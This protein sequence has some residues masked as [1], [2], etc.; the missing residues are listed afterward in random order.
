MY[1]LLRN[2]LD[3]LKRGVRD[4]TQ[5][6]ISTPSTTYHEGAVAAKIERKLTEL[7]Y[8]R[9]FR[10]DSGNVVGILLGREAAPTMLLTSHMDTVD[11][12][13]N[14][15]WE[16]DPLAGN[17][18]DGKIYGLGAADCKGGLAAQMYAGAL[19][20]RSLLPLQGNLV[21]AATVAEGNGC[22]TGI[23][24]FLKKTISDIG[25]SP[26][27]AVLG[28][29]TNLG[30][31]YGH[32]GWVQIELKLNG[33]NP[34]HV[35]D[36]VSALMDSFQEEDAASG[37]TSET[38]SPRFQDITERGERSATIT[39]NRRMNN[40]DEVEDVL[41]Q[42]RR[43]ARL[44][45][46]DPDTSIQVQVRQGTEKMYNGRTELVRHSSSGWSIDPYDPL[47]VRA[48]QSLAAAGTRVHPGRWEL[49]RFGMGTAGSLLS[50][51]FNVPTVGFGPGAEELAHAC[52]EYV[53]IDKLEEAVYG[54]AVIAQGLIGIPVYGWTSDEI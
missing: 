46:R 51:E 10:D 6:L 29:P 34:F 21:F 41:H 30:L 4:F 12:D 7:G 32:D 37:A 22:S 1:T 14:Q 39:L 13:R 45:A 48:Q 50:K 47:V 17:I 15:T 11:A 42:I 28:E 31:F 27:Y 44:V 16:S 24:Q 40:T 38:D 3:G 18:K 5:E 26:T 52:N 2:K 43:D 19:L 9:V 23:R 20:K 49:G 33:S 54:T 8:D 36:A 53:E 25:L 35:N